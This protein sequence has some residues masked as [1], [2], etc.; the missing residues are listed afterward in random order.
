MNPLYVGTLKPNIDD[1]E[2]AS[3]IAGLI[4]AIMIFENG[5]IPPNINF[6]KPNINI[7]T[8]D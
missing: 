2:A 8:E 3:G 1:L 7:P 4:K 6:E 5:F